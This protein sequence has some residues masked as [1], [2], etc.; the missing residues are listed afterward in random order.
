LIIDVLPLRGKEKL[1]VIFSCYRH[2][3][4][5]GQ[6]ILQT[7][8]TQSPTYNFQLASHQLNAPVLPIAFSKRHL[9]FTNLTT[10]HPTSNIEL[11]SHQLNASVLPTSFS[12]RHPDFTNFTT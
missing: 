3:G 9:D 11:A 12:K 10:Q 5:M 2:Y 4:P 1:L 6:S 7:L 8:M